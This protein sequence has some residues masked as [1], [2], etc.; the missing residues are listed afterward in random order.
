[1]AIP[2]GGVFGRHEQGR[3]GPIF[4]KTP[5]CYGFTIIAK[6]IPGREDV[7]YEYARNIEKAV[8]RPAGL[9]R[10][11]QAALPP[12]GALPD[13]GGHLL[14]VSGYFRYRLRQVHR[15]RRSPLFGTASIP[16]SR[17]SRASP[18]TGRRMPWRS[19][20]SFAS[21]SAQ[22]SSNTVSIPTQA[23]TRSRKRSS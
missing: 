18:R 14:H 7:F 22:A 16:C 21:I 8:P 2:K 10:G 17:T 3:Y 1:M 9:P 6:I 13:Q 15:G 12:L 5:A 19:S 20:N 4:P 23:P 11:A